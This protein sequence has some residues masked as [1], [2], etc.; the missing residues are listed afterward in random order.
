M[1]K[2]A[3]EGREKSLGQEHASTLQTVNN[4]GLLYAHQGKLV[5]AEKMYKQALKGFEKALGPDHTSTLQTVHNLGLLYANQG[6]LDEAKKWYR[7]VLQGYA[8]ALEAKTSQIENKVILVRIMERNYYSNALM[9][10]KSQTNVPAGDGRVRGE[11]PA[12]TN[13]HVPV[14]AERPGDESPKPQVYLSLTPTV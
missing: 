1:Y 11:F 3:L 9:S 4:L 12:T 8:K 2:R 7:G 10:A 5:E 6:K 13:R 14:T